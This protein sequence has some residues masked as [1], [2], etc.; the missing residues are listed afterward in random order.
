M[1]YYWML[2]GEELEER[3][4]SSYKGQSRIVSGY[5]YHDAEGEG[6]SKRLPGMLEFGARLVEGL[7]GRTLFDLD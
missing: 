6:W 1:S 2:S 3:N 7:I 5:G 4:L